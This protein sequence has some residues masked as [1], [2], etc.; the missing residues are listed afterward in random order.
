MKF[1]S[2][3]NR[4][5]EVEKEKARALLR[6]TFA[7]ILTKVISSEV[8]SRYRVQLE[9][10]SSQAH[11]VLNYRLFFYTLASDRKF[12]GRQ[13]TM[14][15]VDFYTGGSLPEVGVYHELDLR[16]FELWGVARHLEKEGEGPCHLLSMAPAVAQ[17]I[18]MDHFTPYLPERLKQL[19]LAMLNDSPA[20]PIKENRPS[21]PENQGPA[22]GLLNLEG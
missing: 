2:D 6:S 5:T 19:K 13:L 8:D 22:G 16:D 12:F 9:M 10:I 3:F 1:S 14:H 15:R 17:V 7:P 4:F 21:I 11:V 18:S 20:D